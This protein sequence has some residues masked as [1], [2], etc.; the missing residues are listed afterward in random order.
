MVQALLLERRKMFLFA[1]N[2]YL[3][4]NSFNAFKENRSVCFAIKSN[5]K[6]NRPLLKIETFFLGQK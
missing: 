3:R 1:L 4:T 2:S 6:T 5:L